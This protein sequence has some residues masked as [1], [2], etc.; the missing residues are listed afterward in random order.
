MKGGIALIQI[1]LVLSIALVVAVIC[2]ATIFLN[3]NQI[4]LNKMMNKFEKTI[5]K[6]STKE[7][8]ELKGTYGK[9][10]GNGNEIQ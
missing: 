3:I 2:V 6:Y 10:Y 9:L 5:S 4:N 8:I 7:I 1:L